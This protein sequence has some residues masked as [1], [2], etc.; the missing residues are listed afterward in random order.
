MRGPCCIE[1]SSPLRHPDCRG[2]RA[3]KR[4]RIATHDYVLRRCAM[5][6]KKLST[7]ISLTGQHS[8]RTVCPRLSLA[9]VCDASAMNTNEQQRG[10]VR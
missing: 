1:V 8:S 5:Y 10:V 9:G 4:A 3:A 2:A 7:F 6:K